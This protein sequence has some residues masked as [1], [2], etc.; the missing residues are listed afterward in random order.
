MQGWEY[1]HK[2]ENLILDLLKTPFFERCIKL[3]WFIALQDPMMHLEEDLSTGAAFDKNVF[4]EFV[5]SGNCVNYVVWPALF[6][7]KNGPLLYK[8]V[9]QA[10]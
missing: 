9:V 6:L 4:K 1:E 3:C 7:H 5:Q 8:G 10:Y 2:N